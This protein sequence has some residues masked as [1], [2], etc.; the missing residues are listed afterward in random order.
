MNQLLNGTWFLE[1]YEPGEKEPSIRTEA[2]VPGNVELDLFRNGLEPD[3]LFGENEY[4]Y[5]KYES[6]RWEFARQFS[7]PCIPDGEEAFLVFE[8]LNCIADIFID[9]KNVAHYENA[10][11]PHRLSLK[12]ICLSNT[13]HEIKVIIHS[14]VLR[15]R[16]FDYPVSISACEG[17]DEY[18]RL[19]MPPHS[20][21]WDI[22]PRF[23]SAGMWRDVYIETCPVRRIEQTYFATRN[24]DELKADIV[25]KY[26]FS[27]PDADL[28][29]YRIKVKL[30]GKVCFDAAPRFISGEGN[31]KLDSPRLW[32]PRGYGEPNLYL[33]ETE[34]YKDDKLWDRKTEYIGVRELKIDHKMAAGNEGEFL[35]RFNGCRIMAKGANWVP[36]DA[37]HSRDQERYEKAIN[38]FTESGCNIVRL[39]GGNVYEKDELYS[40]CDRN[41]LM[42]WQDFAMACAVYPQ[43]E[44]FLKTIYDES[45]CIIRMLRN[46][47]CI[48]LWCGDNEVDETYSGRGYYPLANRYNAVTRE[49]LPRAARENDPYRLFLPSSPFISD[50]V[51]RYDVP[52]QHNWG[53]RAYF[54]DDF[55]RLTKAHFISECGYHGC[56]S[57]FSLARFIPS[58]ELSDRTGGS[59]KAHSSEY[60]LLYKRG[61]DRN[62]LMADQVRLMFGSEPEDLEEFSFL[63][64]FTQAEAKKFFIERARIGKWRRTGLIWWNMLDG[65]PQISDSVVD[66]YFVKKRAFRAIK[67]V[68]QPTCV[69]LDEVS[70]WTQDVILGNDS[71][72]N[73]CV[74]VTVW[75]ADTNEALLNGVFESEAN[76]NKV[77]GSLRVM[78]GNQRLILIKWK[79]DGREYRNHYLCGYPPFRPE[80]AHRWAKLID[81][82]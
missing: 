23:P 62:R 52:E 69:M 51:A 65:W 67:R 20:F 63:S 2:Q 11:I 49:A 61:Y 12:G 27:T 78:P 19:R 22:M 56:P 82:E 42:V 37:F 29:G 43:D 59:W 28:S 5:H 32:W 24:A 80:D 79:V 71:R 47:P 68:Q 39:W 35:I 74:S 75:D 55:Y 21:G 10:L 6:W 64:Q 81:E 44:E 70:G 14:A 25:F 50:G 41:G 58:D 53:P 1:G 46:H 38:L 48:L 3:P 72:E 54:K 40:L 77:I 4:L 17:S 8:G 13:K 26:R 15:A 60:A 66:W 57:P 33:A 16:S 30:D 36:M 76:E 18:T 31:I 34:L 9:E 73:A 45:S 7:M